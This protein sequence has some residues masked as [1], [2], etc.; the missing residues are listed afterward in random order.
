MTAVITRLHILAAFASFIEILGEREQGET[1]RP[2]HP[3]R[4]VPALI[5]K[6]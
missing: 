5:S 3:G 6:W 4:A 1:A 2:V